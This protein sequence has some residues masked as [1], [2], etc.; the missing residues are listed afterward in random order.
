MIRLLWISYPYITGQTWLR[1][2][3]STLRHK[4][5]GVSQ[6]KRSVFWEVIVLVILNKTL[7]I[8]TCVLFRT[9]S[10]M[11]LL[12]CTVTKLLITNIYYV[13]FLIPVSI[14]QETTLVQFAQYNTFS[15]IPPS[16]SMHFASRVRTWRVDR[17]YWVLCTLQWNSSSSETVRNR[18]HLHIQFLLRIILWHVN[19]L[20]DDATE[21]QGTG[22]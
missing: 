20:L 10:E 13:L 16:T 22:R 18:T 9:V 15:K 8:S 7:C 21:L 4:L 14:V 12:H 3:C 2:K 11:D 17:L 1:R 5:Y 19:P 6:E